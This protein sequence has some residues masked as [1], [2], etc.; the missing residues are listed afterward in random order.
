MVGFSDCGN[1][2]SGSIKLGG[3]FNYL[4]TC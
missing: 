4:T 2:P 1:E 3:I